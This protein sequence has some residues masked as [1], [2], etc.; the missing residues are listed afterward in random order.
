MIA[1]TLID[2]RKAGH[3]TGVGDNLDKAI[4]ACLWSCAR[5]A[6]YN[7]PQMLV[8][9]HLLKELPMWHGFCPADTRLSEYHLAEFT[10]Y[11]R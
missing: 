2:T 5:N 4:R 9:K 3:N 8:I 11:I 10:I 1:V 7:L 6:R